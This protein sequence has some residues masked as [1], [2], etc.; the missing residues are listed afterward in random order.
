LGRRGAA[1]IEF[2]LV[3]TAFFIMLFGIM[4]W[5]WLFFR[6]SQFMDAVLDGTRR[7]V[8]RSQTDASLPPVEAALSY[9]EA[10]LTAYGIDPALTTIE[11]S[12]SGTSPSEVL[13]VTAWMPYEPLIG[14][15]PT[16]DTI[17]AEMS[18]YLEIQD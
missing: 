17:N 5:G 1:A 7:A 12:Y 15:W 13:V 6:R 4:D 3:S 10:N 18:M 9:T 16:P 14:M 2:A 8:T 11:A